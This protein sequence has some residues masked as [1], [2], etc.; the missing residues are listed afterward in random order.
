M[1]E[2]TSV[3]ENFEDDLPALIRDLVT[4]GLHDRATD[5][6]VDPVEDGFRTCYRVDGMIHCKRNLSVEDGTHLV[7]QIKVAAQFRTDRIMKPM[8]NRILW[9][10][11]RGG[12]R[13]IRVTLVPVT[14]SEAAHL[15]ILSPP[16]ETLT[17]HQLG[18]TDHQLE[19]VRNCITQPEGLILVTG[20][21]GAGKTMTMYALVS[22]LHLESSIAASVEDPVEYSLPYVR[23]VQVDTHHGLTMHEGLRA[24]LRMDPD[25]ILVGETRDS[26]SAVTVA[27][28]ASSGRFVLTT[29][30]SRDALSAIET[31]HYLSV[32]HHMLGNTLRLVV[33]QD[34]V[35]KLCDR[36][37]TPRELREHE[38]ALFQAEGVQPPDTVKDPVGCDACRNYGYLGRTG[39]FQVI[40]ID[41][42]M[43]AAIAGGKGT[44]RLR[45][46]IRAR[47]V[48]SLLADAYEKVACGVT[49]MT[50]V[51]S[52]YS[53]VS[54]EEPGDAAVT[55]G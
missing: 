46:M 9:D 34:L 41:E 30:H 4:D 8:E 3:T 37:A 51:A 12:A 23:Q 21:T 2:N 47:G 45:R 27:Q 28:A 20:P 36:C 7:N 19:I 13:S 39:I 44:H 55:S 40:E 16:K 17:A 31:M 10:D 24:L 1:P 48:P 53:A 26:R 50:E 15:R 52:L 42:D 11:G 6:H 33:G 43:S 38:A 54:G 5:I 22:L 32:P 29:V 14:G 49:S 18:M 35:R 25:V